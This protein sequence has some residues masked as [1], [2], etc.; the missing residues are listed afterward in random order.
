MKKKVLAIL[1]SGTMAAGMLT[2][3]GGDSSGGVDPRTALRRQIQE[4]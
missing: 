3:C 4:I 2:G 1:L